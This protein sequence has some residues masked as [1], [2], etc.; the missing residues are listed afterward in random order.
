MNYYD[1]AIA[2]GLTHERALLFAAA[3]THKNKPNINHLSK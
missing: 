2:T 1:L 3:M